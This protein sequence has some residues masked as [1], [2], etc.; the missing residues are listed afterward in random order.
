MSAVGVVD[1]LSEDPVTRR[2]ARERSDAVKLYEIDLAASKT[3]GK[4]EGRIE[5]KAEGKIEGRTEGRTEV[6]LELLTL[7]FGDLSDATRAQVETASAEQFD[8]WI[9][10]VLTAETLDRVLVP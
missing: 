3:E 10:R 9:E 1:Q 8:S 7:R 4:A 5:G 6:L 2:L